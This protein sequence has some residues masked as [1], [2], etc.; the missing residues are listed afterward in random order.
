[1]LCIVFSTPLRIAPRE[2]P[3]TLGQQQIQQFVENYVRD[4]VYLVDI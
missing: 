4:E 3:F 1:M 2:K